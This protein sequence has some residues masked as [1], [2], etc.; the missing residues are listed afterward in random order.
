MAPGT[1]FEE[2][3]LGLNL[4]RDTVI[5]ETRR[6]ICYDLPIY[7][8]MRLEVSEYAGLTLAVRDATVRTVVRPMYDQVAILILDDDR[9]FK[10]VYNN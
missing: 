2:Q 5:N 4:I 9:E 10:R 6:V 8:D 3:Q 1:D 7:N